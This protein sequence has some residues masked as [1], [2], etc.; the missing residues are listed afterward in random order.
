MCVHVM[1][2][3]CVWYKET[4]RERGETETERGGRDRDR[5]RNRQTNRQTH[6]HTDR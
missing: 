2:R 1:R 3:V 5:D 4:M 6:R